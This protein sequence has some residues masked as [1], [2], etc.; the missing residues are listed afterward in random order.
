VVVGTVVVVAVV[1]VV[2][3]DVDV[4]V[5]V[6]VGATEV[7]VVVDEVVVVVPPPPPVTP[8][9]DMAAEPTANTPATVRTCL[10]ACD[11]ITTSNGKWSNA[12][13]HHSGERNPSREP[14]YARVLELNRSRALT[15][16]RHP[17]PVEGYRLKPS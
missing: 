10:N 2:D 6:V 9:V 8:H 16:P 17:H 1:V 4:V 12:R 3:V 7:E 14:S 5:D 15:L 13:E 11:H